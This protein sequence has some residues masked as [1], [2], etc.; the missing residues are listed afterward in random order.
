MAMDMSVAL[1]ITAGV[2]G[3]QAVDRLNTKLRDLGQQGEKS[4]KQLRQAYQQLPAQLQDVA[5]SLAGG[6]N[7]FMVL[8]QQGSQVSTQFGG[9]GN[10]IRGITSLITPARLAL[11]GL[12]GALAAVG[13]AALQGYQ[14]SIQIQR[15]IALTGNYAGMTADQFERAAVRIQRA[16]GSTAAASREMLIG[17]IGAGAFGPGSIEEVASAMTRLQR[18]SGQSTE[19]VVKMFSGMSRGVAEWAANANRAYNFLSI[20]QY[21]HIKL[22]EEQGRQEEAM[23]VAANALNTA[24]SDR[25]LELG[26]LERGWNS[27]KSTASDAWNAMLNIGRQEDPIAGQIA[28]LQKLIDASQRLRDNMRLRGQPV[29]AE[30]D[31]ERAIKSQ[32][33]ALQEQLRLRQRAA[34]QTSSR[35]QATQK[36]IEADKKAEDERKKAAAQ[37]LSDEK[38]RESVLQSLRDEIIKLTA[39]EDE[40]TMAKLRSL[41]ATPQ[42]IA[43]AMA[44]IKANRELSRVAEENK[45]NERTRADILKQLH[46][47]LEKLVHSEEDLALNRLRGA[48]ATEKEIEDARRLT[49]AIQAR[50]KAKEDEKKSEQLMQERSRAAAQ[51]RQGT[52]TDAEKLDQEI[53]RIQELYNQGYLAAD[54]YYKAIDKARA[55][56][57]SKLTSEGDAVTKS[58][59]TPEEKLGDDI[60]RLKGLLDAG[61]ISLETYSRAVA[62]ARDEFTELADKGSMIGE[63]KKA[64][65]GFGKSA[66]DAF[67]DFAFAANKATE[68]V[69]DR[70]KQLVNSVLQDI[71][72]MLVYKSITQPLFS[73]ISGMIPSFANGGIMTDQGALPLNKYASGGIANSPQLALFGEGRMPEAYVPLPDGRSIP[74]TMEGG[75]G[76]TSVVV[77]VNM[78]SGQTQVQNERGAGDLGRVI[79]GAVKA[80]LINQKRPGG[81]LAAA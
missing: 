56:F 27:V 2:Q 81:L 11:T 49:Q 45:N 25:K 57:L 79:A 4:A 5:V 37:A 65:E 36:A 64:I 70:F 63:L 30:S 42:Q 13:A 50:K 55:D 38:A 76:Q 28:S 22:L 71:A 16:A 35:A 39:G 66:A 73:A 7:P 9:I 47:E 43:D 52:L 51:I 21:K 46:G 67:V 48:G 80:E 44:L 18:L 10:A 60:E 75:G 68:S 40:L 72:R 6:Q 17:S 23:R 61:V 20:E 33:A 78:E 1:K 77:N 53:T 74:V 14:E 24:L 19:D 69:G 15:A 31:E 34:E 62:K 54:T 32:L 8:L 29:P 59:R 41:N 58:V 26:L 12:A 3:E